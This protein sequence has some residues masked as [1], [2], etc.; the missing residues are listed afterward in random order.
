MNA[1]DLITNE[2][3]AQIEA[4]DQIDSVKI[5]SVLTT[6]AVSGVPRKSYGVDMSTRELVEA[7]QPVGVIAAQS[8]GDPGSQLTLDTK[9]GSGVAGSGAIA[10]GLPRVEEL[11]EA[12][13]PK[14]QAYVT[15]IEGVVTVFEENNK[16]IVT[17][18]PEIFD[19]GFASRTRRPQ[20]QSQRW[21]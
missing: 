15:P 2:T 14:G 7:H 19:F 18:T 8:L 5:Q 6:T 12:R 4:D 3:A 11:L 21:R 1:G 9:H 10:R 20:S 16:Y 13:T 17:I